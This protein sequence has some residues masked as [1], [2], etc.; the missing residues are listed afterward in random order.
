[1][2]VSDFSFELPPELIAQ[3]PRTDHE[4]DRLLVIDR[5]T[6]EYQDKMFRDFPSFLHKGDVLVL[7]DTKVRKS[8][9][10][11]TNEN[12]GKVEVLFLHP[13]SSDLSLWNVI[14]NHSK[15][16]KVGEKLV[17]EDGTVSYIKEFLDDGIKVLEFKSPIT[18]K[19]FENIGHVPLPPYIKREDELSDEKTYQT[20]YSKNIGSSASPT[21]GL[22]FTKEILKEIEEKGVEVLYITLHVGM[23]TFMPMHS[24]VL[25][26]HKMHSEYFE[27]SEEVAASINA[28]KREGRRIVA[29]GTTVMRT[30]ESVWDENTKSVV[31]QK[32][33][34]DIFIYPGFTFCVCDELLT[35]F[36]TPESTLFALV[37]AFSSMDIAKT[38]YKHAVSE[39]YRFFS[40]G[41]ATFFK[42]S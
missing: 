20:I 35:N 10:F 15:R 12:G 32:G 29:S 22:H 38:A 30:L 25:E 14:T 11:A 19:F 26:E 7:N 16:R 39:K 2:Q 27:V 42:I 9:L 3:Y 1:M 18:E 13:V 31:P 33:N 36:H 4:N 6:G 8:R 23:G 28:A 41:D 24:Q 5:N 40:Y 34:T 17:F 37:C 21:S